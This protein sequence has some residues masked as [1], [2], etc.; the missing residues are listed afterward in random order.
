M[1]EPDHSQPFGAM[2][3]ESSG[4]L[5]PSESQYSYGSESAQDSPPD[6][7]STGRLPDAQSLKAP[8]SAQPPVMDPYDDGQQYSD[9]SSDEY[10]GEDP[11]DIPARPL[12]PAGSIGS[13]RFPRPAF[14]NPDVLTI[15]PEMSV[16]DS[17]NLYRS[18]V[19][20]NGRQSW[21]GQSRDGDGSVNDFNPYDDTSRPGSRAASRAGSIRR[22]ASAI[23]ALET[24]DQDSGKKRPISILR[25]S[26]KGKGSS[27][28][29][30][31]VGSVQGNGVRKAKSSIGFSLSGKKEEKKSVHWEGSSMGEGVLM[32]SD[33][34]EE[35]V[36]NGYT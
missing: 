33:G 13:T 34:K 23:G 35:R 5:Q 30:S 22:S 32:L 11:D 19:E 18:P 3:V 25:P 26:G 27:N 10:E 28:G 1:D 14:L 15:L 2:Q 24:G 29:G 17:D 12:S 36:G 9:A 16:E 31:E 8:Q 20:A 6:P 7:P 4:T 21:R